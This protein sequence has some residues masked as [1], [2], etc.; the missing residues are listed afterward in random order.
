MLAR[1]EYH[2]VVWSDEIDVA[3]KR[4]WEAGVPVSQ[5]PAEEP[6]A[7]TIAAFEDIGAGRNIIGPFDDVD[8]LFDALTRDD[9]NQKAL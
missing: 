4:L 1:V 8:T 2:T 9:D 6:N 5:G 3:P 7:D